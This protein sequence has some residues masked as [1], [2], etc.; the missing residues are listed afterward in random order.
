MK[1]FCFVDELYEFNGNNYISKYNSVRFLLNLYED[2]DWTFSFPLNKEY[3][4]DKPAT[5]IPDNAKVIELPYWNSILSY[6]RNINKIK[7]DIINRVEDEI[8]KSDVVWVRLPSPAGNL[9]MDIARKKE[10]KIICH[11]ATDILSVHKKYKGIKKISSYL[12]GQYIHLSTRKITDSYE[13]IRI[14]CTGNHLERAYPHPTTCFFVDTESE[15]DFKNNQEKTNNFIYVGRLIESKGIKELIKSWNKLK[16]QGAKLF[17]VGHGE[18]SSYV[19]EEARNN[20]NIEFL[21]FLTGEELKKLYSKTDCLILPTTTF[22]E[23]FPRVIAEAWCSGL[24]VISTDVGGIK[25]LGEHKNNILFVEPNNIEQLSNA[26]L[27]IYEDDSLLR[28]LAD[29]GKEAAEQISKTNML[30]L[31]SKYIEA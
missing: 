9:I 27:N 6:Y 22:P 13:N 24:G 3:T 16:L 28:K 31:V 20:N 17:I 15:I 12:L 8:E 23:G 7:K 26:I 21:G 18:L 29:G 25:G 10:K 30:K 19:E 4:I 11:L 1:V 2:Y 5:I 14:M